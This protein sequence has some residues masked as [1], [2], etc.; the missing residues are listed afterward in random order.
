MRAGFRNPQQYQT[1]RAL[2]QTCSTLRRRHGG[3]PDGGADSRLSPTTFDFSFWPADAPFC[4]K[5]SRIPEHPCDKL[6]G[7]PTYTS[8]TQSISRS[9]LDLCHRHVGVDQRAAEHGVTIMETTKQTRLS[10]HGKSYPWS[11]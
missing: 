10:P 6:A 4:F 1:S 11:F 7:L 5:R 2:K 8:P 9:Y 3:A